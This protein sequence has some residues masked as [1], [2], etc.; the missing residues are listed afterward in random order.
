MMDVEFTPEDMAFRD[1]VRS[2]IEENYQKHLA[3]WI[4]VT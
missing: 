3:H 1:E 4:A 2:F